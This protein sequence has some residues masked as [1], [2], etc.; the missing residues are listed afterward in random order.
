MVDNELLSDI[1]FSCVDGG[2]VRGHKFILCARSAHFL[3]MFTSGRHVILFCALLST[4][5]VTKE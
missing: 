4:V 3:A 1:S 5:H 2:V